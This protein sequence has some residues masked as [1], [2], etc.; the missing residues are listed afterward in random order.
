MQHLVNQLKGCWQV[1]P[2]LVIGFQSHRTKT[3]AHLLLHL[4]VKVAKVTKMDPTWLFRF[5][6]HLI[7]FHKVTG[8][9]LLCIG[10]RCKRH[11]SSL[12]WTLKTSTRHVMWYKQKQKKFCSLNSTAGRALIHET[13]LFSSS[14]TVHTWQLIGWWSGFWSSTI[15]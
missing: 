7:N 4:W 12:N 2:I 15:P 3:D 6:F 14:P 1:K 5:T 8:G 10:K 11:H 9:L 13:R